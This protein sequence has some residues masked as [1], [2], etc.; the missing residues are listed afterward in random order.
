MKTYRYAG[1]VLTYSDRY[2]VWKAFYD[3]VEVA[4]A[5]STNKLINKLKSMKLKGE[6]PWKA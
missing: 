2:N 1:C 6:G 3:Q 5:S 4:T